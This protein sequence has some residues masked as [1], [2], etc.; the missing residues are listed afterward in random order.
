MK[1]KRKKILVQ[2]QTRITTEYHFLSSVSG[3]LMKAF[4]TLCKC[5]FSVA[6]ISGVKQHIAGSEHKK[7]DR[8]ATTSAA[9]NTLF[10]RAFSVEHQKV[11]AA[12]MT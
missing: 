6:R 2:I 1:S 4:C 11:L 12:E 7:N 10:G 8:S 9:I 3:N 5:K